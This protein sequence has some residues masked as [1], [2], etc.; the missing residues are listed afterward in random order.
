MS[1]SLVHGSHRVRNRLLIGFGLLGS[2]AAGIIAAERPDG[3]SAAASTGYSVVVISGDGMGPA[4]RTATQLAKYGYKTQP[5]DALPEGGLLKTNSVVP[6]TD[7]AAGATA[8]GTGH[9]AKNN[10]AGLAPNGKKLYNLVEEA[11][12]LGKSTGLVEDHDVTNATMMGFAAHLKNRDNK[13]QAARQYLNETH[14]DVIFGGGEEV[15]YPEGNPGKI[16]DVISDDKST[17]RENLV[18]EAKQTGLPVR[19]EPEDAR[20]ADRPAGADAGPRRRLH[21]RPRDQGLQEGRGSELRP[22]AEAAREGARDPR[23]EPRGVLRRRRRRRARRRRPRARRQDDHPVRSDRQQAGPGGRGV[24]GVEPERA[25]RRHRRSRDRRH[26]GRAAQG[27]VDQQR[28]RRRRPGLRHAAERAA[29]G[30]QD[31]ELSGPFKVHGKDA[32]FK[33]DW[34]T[35]GH[36]GLMVPV[37]A[38]GPGAER[39]SGVHAEHVRAHRRERRAE[40]QPVGIGAAGLSPAARRRA[41]ASRWRGRVFPRTPSPPW[42]RRSFVRMQPP[43]PPE[44]PELD[45]DHRR[46]SGRDRSRNRRRAPLAGARRARLAPGARLDPLPGPAAGH[47]LQPR[48]RLL[49]CRPRRRNRAS[50]GSRPR[51]RRSP[52]GASGRASSS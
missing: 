33:V 12:D 16:P 1:S 6:V 2:L 27:E 34:T 48:S 21:P 42:C 5:M 30:R 23:P 44:S 4:Q 20:R 10:Q 35:P 36:T 11:N 13:A 17:G 31:A 9:K 29:A 7:S 26:D 32:T 18:K 51:S 47:V 14:P 52:P 50:A 49:R 3:A 43:P 24:P 38:V 15:W 28:R 46:D 37:T 41:P 25:P 22:G 19:L 45:P 39:F 40:R 8:M